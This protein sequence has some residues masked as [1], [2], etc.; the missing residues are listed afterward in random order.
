MY[1]GIV[2]SL[3]TIVHL[4][5][6]IHY[7][8]M[9]IQPE[10]SWDDLKIG[11]SM[12]VNGVCLTVTHFSKD[13]FDLTVV[14]ETMR[15]T[16]LNALSLDA[17]VNLERSLTVSD[18]MSGHYVQGHVDAIGEII[19][20]QNDGDHAIIL[21]IKF[22]EKLS[23]Y[24]VKKGFVAIDGMSITII[25]VLENFFTV[26]LIPHTL[27]VTVAKQYKIGTTVNLETDI[28]AKYTEKLLGIQS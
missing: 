20:I 18:R 21:K 8:I 27:A 13:S 6:T 14:P 19:A 28:L 22:P 24:L 9:T 1:S 25:D 12:A 17:L 10:Q 7:L 4:E 2:E 26:T 5:K 15:V 11:D 16:N 3:R 23:K